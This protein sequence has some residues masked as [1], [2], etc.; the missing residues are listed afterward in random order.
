MNRKQKTLTFM[1]LYRT[2]LSY[3][4]HV[5]RIAYLRSGNKSGLPLKLITEAI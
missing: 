4:L 3:M 5:A 1:S 2:Q